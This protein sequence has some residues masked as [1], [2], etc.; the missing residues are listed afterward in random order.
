MQKAAFIITGMSCVNCAARIEKSLGETAGIGRASMNFAMEELLVEFDDSAISRE[1]IEEKVAK[2]GYGIRFKGGAG[3][4]HFGVHGL[5]CASCVNN[6]EKKLLAAPGVTEAVVNLAQESAF[7]R[8]DPGTIAPAGIYAVVT[9]A[10]YRPVPEGTKEDK[11]N[12][13]RS[14]RNWFTASLLL[15]LPVM[16][17][18]GM[19]ENPAVGWMN[20]AL[21]SI[22]Q[23]TAGL[24]FYR[25]SW[26]ALKNRSANMDVL[27]ALGTSAAYFYSVFA[28]FGGHLR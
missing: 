14:Q 24:T 23:F 22:V 13:Y 19:H 15:S 9:D 11:A 1:A 10:G 16:L 7:V 25:G 26:Y 8:F 20:L 17:T 28:F 2:L 5:H 12:E 4:L 6:L 3:E 21:A 27:V 18:M